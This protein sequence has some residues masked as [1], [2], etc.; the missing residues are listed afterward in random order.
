MLENNNMRNN[1]VLN[2]NVLKKLLIQ[3][4]IEPKWAQFS[5]WHTEHS[6]VTDSCHLFPHG[7]VTSS[8]WVESDGQVDT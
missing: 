8:T 3:I 4:E 1:K 5:L 2:Q 6:E 7:F